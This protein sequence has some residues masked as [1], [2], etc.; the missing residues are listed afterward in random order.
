MPA[1]GNVMGN[2]TTACVCNGD[3]P[4]SYVEIL[5]LDAEAAAALVN[6]ETLQAIAFSGEG[7]TAAVDRVS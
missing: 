7:A 1:V 6:P 5:L 3:P 4:E 2:S